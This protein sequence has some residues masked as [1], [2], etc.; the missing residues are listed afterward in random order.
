[1]N[2]TVRRI[3]DELATNGETSTPAYYLYARKELIKDVTPKGIKQGLKL[4]KGR[5]ETEAKFRIVDEGLEVI[6]YIPIVRPEELDLSVVGTH[7]TMF[8]TYYDNYNLHEYTSSRD[9]WVYEDYE[10][11][12]DS[13]ERFANPL[14]CIVDVYPKTTYFYTLFKGG[15]LILSKP[16]QVE[17]QNVQKS[18]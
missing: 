11:L 17:V 7:A 4:L 6:P 10:H 15:N 16:K 14:G 5:M 3:L 18:S 2:D 8:N 1:M 13:Y 9:H 12:K